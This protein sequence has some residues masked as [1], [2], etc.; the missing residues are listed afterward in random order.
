MEV[1]GRCK[2]CG[3]KYGIDDTDGR[4]VYTCMKSYDTSVA[5]CSNWLDESEYELKNAQQ[6]VIM[7][8]LAS[9]QTNRY[10]KLSILSYTIVRLNW[11]KND[12]VALQLIKNELVESV[13]EM[14]KYKGTIS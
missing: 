1:K 9:T 10:Q 3:A 5:L 14:L 2:I 6:L 13:D 4:F 7:R 11:F 12:T 8:R